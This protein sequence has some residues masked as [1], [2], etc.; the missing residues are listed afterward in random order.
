MRC[1]VFIR[2]DVIYLDVIRFEF[3]RSVIIRIEF[4]HSVGESAKII[5]SYSY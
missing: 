2:F 1:D 4:I 3:I 5:A